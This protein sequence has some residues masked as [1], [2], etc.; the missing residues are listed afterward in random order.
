MQEGVEGKEQSSPKAEKA[1]GFAILTGDKLSA[2]LETV[3]GKKLSEQRTY[4]QE[5]VP[6]IPGEPVSCDWRVGLNNGVPVDAEIQLRRGGALLGEMKVRMQK[7]PDGKEVWNIWHRFVNEGERGTGMG[8]YALQTVESFIEGLNHKRQA[9]APTLSFEV[10]QPSVID[11]ALAKGYEFKGEDGAESE[12]MY[13]RFKEEAQTH[14]QDPEFTERGILPSF[15]IAKLKTEDGAPKDMVLIDKQKLEAFA[16]ER[17][18]SVDYYLEAD[19]VT[20]PRT[21]EETG[22]LA[23]QFKSIT[24]TWEELTHVGNRGLPF[25]FRGKLQKTLKG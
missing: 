4:T 2:L 23:S 8:T 18:D 25:V 7:D 22:E 12:A 17:D 20:D 3:D 6:G 16:K 19:M 13:A 15:I 5:N 9:G 24:L 11:F 14:A 21:G 1:T 10:S